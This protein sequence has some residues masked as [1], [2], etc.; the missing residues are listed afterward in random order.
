[1]REY[2]IFIIGK[3][4][5]DTTARTNIYVYIGLSNIVRVPWA[6]WNYNVDTALC[7]NRL[8]FV[9]NFSF[10]RILYTGIVHPVDRLTHPPDSRSEGYN[11]TGHWHAPSVSFTTDKQLS[12][13]GNRK[14]WLRHRAQSYTCTWAVIGPTPYCC[15][16]E[17]VSCWHYYIIIHRHSAALATSIGL[18]LNC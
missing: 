1:M 7:T 15:G 2:T 6:L 12:Y 16:I 10:K 4:E 3:G 18:L 14:A 8:C 9:S 13:C 17:E 5:K 11:I